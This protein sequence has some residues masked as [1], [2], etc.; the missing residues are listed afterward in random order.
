MKVYHCKEV[1]LRDDA[2]Q[3]SQILSFSL[4]EKTFYVTPLISLPCP[5]VI[6]EISGFNF[7]EMFI[8]NGSILPKFL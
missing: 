6:F 3:H 4:F 5:W 8:S 7:R 1:G 2:F